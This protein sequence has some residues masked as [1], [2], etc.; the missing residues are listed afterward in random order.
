MILVNLAATALVCG[1]LAYLLKQRGASPWLT[2]SVI[3]SLA[4]LLTIRM[5]LSEPLALGLALLGWVFYEKNRLALAIVMFALS[6]L[7]KEVGL[8]FPLSI[9][10]WE[11]SNKNWRRSMALGVGSVAPYIIW[12]G[13]LSY[14]LGISQDQ[15]EKSYP[16]LIPF[17]GIRYLSEPYSRL[18]VGLWVLLP[19]LIAGIFAAA[20]LWV[21]K[22]TRSAGTPCWY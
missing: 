10:L 17:W 12:Y 15:V 11:A 1:A 2:L 4:Y 3:F 16:V 7:T 20:I 8:L 9:A 14:W 18:L 6:G 13:F 22:S 21:V 5:D 19:A